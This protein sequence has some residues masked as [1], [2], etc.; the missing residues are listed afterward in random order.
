MRKKIAGLLI[1]PACFALSPILRLLSCLFWLWKNFE[2]Y[3]TSRTL[4]GIEKIR[5][6][7]TLA[8]V[9]HTAVKSLSVAVLYRVHNLLKMAIAIYFTLIIV[10]LSSHKIYAMRDV[11]LLKVPPDSPLSVQ[12]AAHM[13]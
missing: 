8:S 9:G 11:M 7:E 5:G 12:L 3:A 6:L 13:A 4:L 2:R 10:V 1:F